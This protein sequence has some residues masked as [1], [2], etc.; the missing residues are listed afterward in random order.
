MSDVV[1]RFMRDRE[2]WR[3]LEIT[4]SSSE[5]L[6]DGYGGLY[7]K[8]RKRFRQ[9]AASGQPKDWHRLRRWTKYLGLVLPT[10]ASG[11]KAQTAAADYAALAKKLGNLHDLD[12]LEENLKVL[13]E[14]QASPLQPA[15]E[16][17]AQRADKLRRQCER[18]SSQLFSH[19]HDVMGKQ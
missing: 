17:V 3:A 12:L 1:D 11:E 2:R 8:A 5:L 18:T 15:I 13:N 10:L 14:Q 19:R 16:V 9:A 7:R 4:C 6:A